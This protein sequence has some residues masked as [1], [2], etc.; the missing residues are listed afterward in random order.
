MVF[1]DLC[2]FSKLTESEMTKAFPLWTKRLSE[3]LAA[4]SSHIKLMNTCGD[5]VYLVVDDVLATA[6]CATQIS[7]ACEGLGEEIGVQQPLA[8]R[9][10]SHV[11]PELETY[12]QSIQ[13][14]NYLGTHVNI[15]SRLEPFTP[16]GTVYVTEELAACLALESES[17]F[18][19]QYAGNRAP[20]KGAG[21]IRMYRLNEAAPRK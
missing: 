19:C 2:G 17:T 6:A 4:N 8:F 10:S 20:P 1:V 11:A 7:R 3:I 15:A 18:H 16:P 12:D 9:V 21:T 14:M 5:A 13:K